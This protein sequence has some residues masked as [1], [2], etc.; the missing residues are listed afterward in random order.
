MVA[1]YVWTPNDNQKLDFCFTISS[2]FTIVA[3]SFGYSVWYRYIS[4]F[5]LWFLCLVNEFL[6]LWSSFLF[7]LYLDH[8]WSATIFSGWWPCG[9][10]II[11][12]HRG[13]T[14]GNTK[15]GRQVFSGVSKNR[16]SSS[17]QSI[18]LIRNVLILFCLKTGISSTYFPNLMRLREHAWPYGFENLYTIS[19]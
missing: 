13:R 16:R 7:V 14:K 1:L 5:M 10:Q 12:K 8:F 17:L 3:L 4:M 9:F 19:N 11:W 6:G 18:L 2:A 15:Q